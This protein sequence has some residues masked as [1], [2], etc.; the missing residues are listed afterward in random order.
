MDGR[1]RRF[2]EWIRN[3]ILEFHHDEHGGQS[4]TAMGLIVLG[5]VLLVGILAC[6]GYLLQQTLELLKPV[7]SEPEFGSPAAAG[8]W[9]GEQ[10]RSR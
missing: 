9:A 7:F 2:S 1:M 8:D 4:R 5:A 6:G 10:S 3:P